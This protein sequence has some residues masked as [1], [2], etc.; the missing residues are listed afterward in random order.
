[1]P[2]PDNIKLIKRL[3]TDIE[4]GR[5]SDKTFEGLVNEFAKL[6][7]TSL[8]DERVSKAVQRLGE[9]FPEVVINTMKSTKGT[10]LRI[11]LARTKL[12]RIELYK[13]SLVAMN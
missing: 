10:R 9:I 4:K 6:P 1:M 2:T 11:K 12:G 8:S 7:V 5:A 13:S 3:I